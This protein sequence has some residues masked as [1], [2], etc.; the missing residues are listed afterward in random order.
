MDLKTDMIEA[1]KFCVIRTSADWPEFDSSNFN[2][3]VRGIMTHW[4]V[5]FRVEFTTMA[6]RREIFKAISRIRDIEPKL[7]GIGTKSKFYQIHLDAQLKIANGNIQKIWEQ[8][9]T[10]ITEKL[11]S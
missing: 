6:F 3:S 11:V 9:E 4:M 5:Y 1:R 8:I 10:V 7:N 2:S